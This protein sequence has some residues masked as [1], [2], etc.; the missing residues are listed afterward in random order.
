MLIFYMVS[1]SA[2][3]K[4]GKANKDELIGSPE[5][6]SGLVNEISEKIKVG[7][8][9]RGG[10]ILEDDV[11]EGEQDGINDARNL[12]AGSVLSNG[13]DS[14]EASELIGSSRKDSIEDFETPVGSSGMGSVPP[15]QPPTVTAQIQPSPQIPRR[16][17]GLKKYLIGM[18]VI[19]SGLIGVL[20]T[21]RYMGRNG[22]VEFDGDMEG[23]PIS[24][25][26][27]VGLLRKRN[28]VSVK[29]GYNTYVLKDLESKTDIVYSDKTKD[30]HKDKLE[31]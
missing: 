25:V 14:V 6:L 2:R 23:F 5:E 10:Y 9:D 1:K 27:N 8:V 12:V 20:G 3:G 4:N 29:D 11:P 31:V 22:R 30:Y 18:A 15:I 28:E 16:V 26:E 13:S 17:S 21:A 19:G 7:G 24:Y